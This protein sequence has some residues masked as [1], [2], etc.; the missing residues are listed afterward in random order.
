MDIQTHTKKREKEREISSCSASLFSLEN[1]N[2]KKRRRNNENVPCQH[3]NEAANPSHHPASLFNFSLLLLSLSFTIVSGSR[4]AV[5]VCYVYSDDY[6]SLRF[7]ERQSS[8]RMSK[9]KVMRTKGEGREK[10]FF[11]NIKNGGKCFFF[12]MYN[13][14]SR[15][16]TSTA[17]V[18]R[19]MSKTKQMGA[20]LKIQS[21]ITPPH[22][23]S[24]THSTA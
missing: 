19:M 16:F 1:E 12:Q 22:N 21:T 2:K 6:R 24:I 15:L 13:I 18:S 4:F 20:A 23:R 10:S 14:Q 8:N 17:S 3:I 7:P 9:N 11:N 5:S